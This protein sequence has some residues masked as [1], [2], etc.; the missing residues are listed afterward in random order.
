MGIVE[1]NVSGSEEVEE[2]RDTNKEE[3]VS[4]DVSRVIN[5][6]ACP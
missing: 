4:Q 1:L 6:D 3:R 2:E 5:E